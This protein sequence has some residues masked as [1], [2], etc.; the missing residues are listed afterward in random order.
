MEIKVY[1]FHLL[2]V[3]PLHCHTFLLLVYE[4]LYA[5]SVEFFRLTFKPIAHSIF[6]L[7]ITIKLCS[8]GKLLD[9]FK[10]EEIAMGKVW[11]IRRVEKHFP[12]ELINGLHC[13]GC[14][15]RPSIVLMQ[16][17]SDWLQ[18]SVFVLYIFLRLSQKLTVVGTANSSSFSR[19]FC[20]T[21]WCHQM[22][23]SWLEF[24]LL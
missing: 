2:Y 22:I 17:H 11:A 21:K 4:L 10:Q 20:P 8:C 24:S 6:Y 23:W 15:V 18:T 16:D 3:V 5:F 7:L 1:F 14:S 12:T 13:F 19:K 9:G